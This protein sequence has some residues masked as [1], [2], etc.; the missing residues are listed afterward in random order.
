MASLFMSIKNVQVLTELS[1][2]AAQRRLARVRAHFGL[3]KYQPV[4]VMDYCM[5]NRLDI[6]YVMKRLEKG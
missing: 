2:S 4:S 5:Y 6:E 1:A 3:S